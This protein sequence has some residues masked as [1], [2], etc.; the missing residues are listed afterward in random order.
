MD[1]IFEDHP[2]ICRNPSLE[3]SGRCPQLLWCAVHQILCSHNFLNNTNGPLTAV[4]MVSMT[5]LPICPFLYRV[6]LWVWCHC[7]RSFKEKELYRIAQLPIGQFFYP[8]ESH[9]LLFWLTVIGQERS[10]DLIQKPLQ[11]STGLSSSGG[12]I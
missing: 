9:D 12:I 1:H 4:P 6:F 11:F 8:A 2:W 3:A 10:H 5:V 7:V